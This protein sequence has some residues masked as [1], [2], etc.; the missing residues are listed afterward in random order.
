MCNLQSPVSVGNTR[1]QCVK[2]VK[3]SNDSWC[4]NWAYTHVG[5]GLAD[6]TLCYLLQ[7]ACRA[8]SV[9]LWW[10]RSGRKCT[11]WADLLLGFRLQQPLSDCLAQLA[12]GSI[13]QPLLA[14]YV[15]GVQ[16]SNK[17]V[18]AVLGQYSV[19]L[20]VIGHGPMAAVPRDLLARQ[21]HHHTTPAKSTPCGC[22][23][24]H[25]PPSP[26]NRAHRP[27]ALT[28]NIL[29]SVPGPSPPNRP[30]TTT[31]SPL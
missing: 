13:L 2:Q 7:E 8:A 1:R 28:C 6:R 23:T 10:H 16:S 22:D 27:P 20:Q 26:A 18:S 29:L 19:V 11:R 24:A 9:A 15:C 12:A 25:R 30:H 3:A 31:L 4:T 21:H 5:V 14:M 17:A